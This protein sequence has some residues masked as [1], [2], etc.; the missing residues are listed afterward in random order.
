MSDI[1]K[2]PG[3]GCVI[4]EHCK[5]FTARDN[6]LYQPYFLDPP[7]NVDTDDV[8][9]IMYCELYMTNEK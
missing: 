3:V 2:C 9:H 8:K 7:F 1:T 5:R 6:E 4:K